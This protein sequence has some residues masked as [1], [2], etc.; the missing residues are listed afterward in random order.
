MGGYIYGGGPFSR[1]GLRLGVR[2]HYLEDHGAGRSPG[3][4]HLRSVH[5]VRVTIFKRARAELAMAQT[6]CSKTVTGVS[7]TCSSPPRIGGLE[8]RY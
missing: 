2:P 8:K 7:I 1:N 3:D 5:E 4:R 6:S